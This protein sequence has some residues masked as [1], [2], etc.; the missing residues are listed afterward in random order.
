MSK[1]R[2]ALRAQA[3]QNVKKIKAL[4]DENIEIGKQLLLLCDEE[5][6]FTEKMETITQREGRKKIKVDRLIGRIH[7][8]EDFKDESTGETVTIERS[9]VVRIDKDWNF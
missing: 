2:E 3:D 6:W 4:K 8:K 7:W 1:T 5:Q 9:E